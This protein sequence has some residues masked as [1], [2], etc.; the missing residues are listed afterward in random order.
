MSLD[1]SSFVGLENGQRGAG[2][3][4]SCPEAGRRASRGVNRKAPGKNRAVKGDLD[5]KNRGVKRGL[6]SDW[7]PRPEG[8]TPKPR[9][10]RGK[11]LDL[12]AQF[13]LLARLPSFSLFFLFCLSIFNFTPLTPRNFCKSFRENKVFRGVRHFLP[14]GLHP[15]KR[16]VK[17][18]L[19]F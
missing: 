10:K 8:L 18:E 15:E 2:L 4:I 14:L 3:Q 16:G 12:N 5:E 9:G 13:R 7:S 11:I 1:F 19:Q 17:T 6:P